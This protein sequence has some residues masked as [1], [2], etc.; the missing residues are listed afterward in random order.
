MDLGIKDKVAVV[1]GG[2]KG[3]G[4][5]TA[6]G[7]AAEG[8]HVAICARGQAALDATAK[9]VEALGVK[10]YAAA[11]DV[12]SL[13]S[14]GGFL[15]DAKS[16]LGGVD[17]L[18]NNPSAFSLSDDEDAWQASHD[19]DLMATVRATRIVAPWMEERGGGA[20]VSVSSTAALEAGPPA[21]SA[22]K[23]AVVAHAKSMAAK[24]GQQNIRIN[25]VAPGAIHVEGGF[26]DDVKQRN[27]QAYEQAAA[28]T[29]FGRIGRPE[30]VADVIV[31]L[32]SAR[33]QWVSGAT[34]LVD[35]VQHKAIF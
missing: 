27:P 6:L 8:A 14:L 34:V 25:C 28:A 7:L 11:C 31:F 4:R 1:T 2:S 23:L 3:I 12:S 32:A 18:V 24:L 26:W 10:A 17:V 15:E 13:D 29:A 22:A 9:E 21:Y 19:I 5:V 20:I 30:E 33:A 35:G 16:A